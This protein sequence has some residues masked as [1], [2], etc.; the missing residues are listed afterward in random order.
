M[1][2]PNIL[3][4]S[5]KLGRNLQKISYDRGC[6]LGMNPANHWHF[7]PGT[8][9]PCHILYFIVQIQILV[10]SYFIFQIFRISSS[11]TY[12]AAYPKP[13]QK[14]LSTRL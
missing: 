2:A 7:L 3:S 13:K 11:V 9:S 1:P 6:I 14:L 4:D 10:C 5:L 12:Q 8:H